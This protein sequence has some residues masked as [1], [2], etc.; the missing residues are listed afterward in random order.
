MLYV[1]QYQLSRVVQKCQDD[2]FR[3]D[4]HSKWDKIN[5]IYRKMVY[6]EALAQVHPSRFYYNVPMCQVINAIDL[7]YS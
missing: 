2:A 1:A 3:D 5:N 7:Y 4:V 6:S